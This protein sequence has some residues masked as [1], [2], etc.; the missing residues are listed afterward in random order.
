[1]G[2]GGA[3]GTDSSVGSGGGNG[4]CIAGS[5]DDNG[6]SNDGDIVGVNSQLLV[7]RKTSSIVPT[8]LSSSSSLSLTSVSSNLSSLAL[9]QQSQHN[10]SIHNSNH[11]HPHPHHNHHH[12]HHMQQQHQQII[13][14]IAQLKEDIRSPLAAT[15]ANSLASAASPTGSACIKIENN[16]NICS[17]NSSNLVVVVD[18]QRPPPLHEPSDIYL[19]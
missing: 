13:Q 14:H 1:M 15:R 19:V 8:A 5:N 16:N 11:H 9:A 10:N 2:S 3:E 7:S 18:H 4:L 12:H 6:G 17:N